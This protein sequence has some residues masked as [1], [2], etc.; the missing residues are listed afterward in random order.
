VRRCY[1]EGFECNQIAKEKIKHFVSKE[2][3]NIDGFG[4]KIVENFWKLK[5]VKLPQDIFKLDYEKIKNLDGWGN[6]STLNLKYSIDNKREIPLDKFIYSLGIRHIGQENAKLLARH[7]KSADNFFKLSSNKVTSELANIDGIGDTQIKS[8]INFFL[9]KTN[10][11]VLLE[12]KKTL[13]ITGVVPTNQSGLLKN[14][15]FMFTGKLKGMSRA[16]AKSII[17]ENSGKIINNI[18][19][20]LDYLIIG[21]KPTTKKVNTAKELNIKVIT[22]DEWLKMLN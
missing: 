20:K 15:T 18:N 14:K 11:K 1:G 9:N 21:E 10:L 2:A 6:I 16:E 5:L 12:L 7:L 19:K 13:K 17:E 3:F 22:Q 4:K 8:I